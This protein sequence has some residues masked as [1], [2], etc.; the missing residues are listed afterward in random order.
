VW[1]LAAYGATL[2]GF[3]CSGQVLGIDP[4]NGTATVLTTSP[5]EMFFGASER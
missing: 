2:F 4:T 5:G 3:T 1:G